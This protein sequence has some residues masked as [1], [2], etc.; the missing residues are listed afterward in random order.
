[1][2]TDISVLIPVHNSGPFI[3]EAIDSVINQTFTNFELVIIDDGSK[4]S[5]PSI[6]QSAQKKDNRVKI[7]T[8][9]SNKGI[10]E[11][12]NFGLSKSS[13]QFIA[14]MDSDDIMHPDRLLAQYELFQKYPQTDVAGC[15]VKNFHPTIFL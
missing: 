7:Y 10:V 1:M 2:P 11:A 6:I 14:R 9:P 15:L 13:S 8:L 3:A 4:D 5:T 12:L